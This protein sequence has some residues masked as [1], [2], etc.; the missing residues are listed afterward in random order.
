MIAKRVRNLSS[1]AQE[2]TKKKNLKYLPKINMNKK[3]KKN[4]F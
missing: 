4:N 1:S 3:I 2:K